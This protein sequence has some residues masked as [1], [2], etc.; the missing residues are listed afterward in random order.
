MIRG[1]ASGQCVVSDYRLDRFTF[2]RLD[3]DTA[4]LVYWADQ[5]TRCGGHPVPSPVWATSLYEKRG[6]RWVNVL[7][8]H[9]PAAK[10]AG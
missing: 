3:G 8:S 10:P 5:T 6:G 9:T 7:Y 4:V 2:R 1:I